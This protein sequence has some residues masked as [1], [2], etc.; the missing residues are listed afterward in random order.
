MP[1]EREQ[2]LRQL[3]LVLKVAEKEANCHLNRSKRLDLVESPDDWASI[4]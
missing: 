2:A 1:R 4:R 3:W